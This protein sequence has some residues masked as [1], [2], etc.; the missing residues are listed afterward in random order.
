MELRE[1]IEREIAR[2]YQEIRV[3][4]LG[5]ELLQ[6]VLDTLPPTEQVHIDACLIEGCEDHH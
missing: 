6:L 5:I 4:R 3:I 2:Q 1:K